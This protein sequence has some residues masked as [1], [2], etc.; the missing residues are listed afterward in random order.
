MLDDGSQRQYRISDITFL[1]AP[2]PD[3][4][5]GLIM[6]ITGST[7]RLAFAQVSFM[8]ALRQHP[9]FGLG[10]RRG[11]ELE[12]RQIFYWIMGVAASLIFI[13]LVVTPIS[14][15]RIATAIPPSYERR[16][17]TAVA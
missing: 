17:G 12:R 11:R 2:H 6:P 3:G 9:R 14:A 10:I 16:L 7:L 1:V 8:E 4:A 5:R 15:E 13:V